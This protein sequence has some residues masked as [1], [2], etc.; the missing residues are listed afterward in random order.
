M[1]TSKP[2]EKINHH[3]R[4]FLS[5]AAAATA[6]VQLGVITSAKAQGGNR[7]SVACGHAGDA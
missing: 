4:R 5:T 7:K 3:R 6:A 1:D 2:F